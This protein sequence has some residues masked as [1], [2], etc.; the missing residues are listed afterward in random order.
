MLSVLTATLVLVQTDWK[1]YDLEGIKLSLPTTPKRVYPEGAPASVRNWHAT[2]GRNGVGVSIQPSDPNKSPDVN[3]AS[4]LGGFMSAYRGRLTAQSDTVLN[5]WPG[6]DATLNFPGLGELRYVSYWTEKGLVTVTAGGP[7]QDSVAFGKRVVES[8]SLGSTFSKGPQKTAGPTWKRTVL[9]PSTVSIEFP[10]EP[11]SRGA[12]ESKDDGFRPHVWSATYGNREY[13]VVLV[14]GP[15]QKDDEAARWKS[16]QTI[17]TG[18]LTGRRAKYLSRKPS[19]LLGEKS[20]KIEGESSDGATAILA[21][22]TVKGKETFV[23]VASVPKVLRDSAEVTRFF[24][25]LKP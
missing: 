3:L 6:I 18:T 17:N 15:E 16:I 22:T 5:G 25:S 11:I 24:S 12:R 1:T 21:E 8:L 4:S 2:E 23:L 13:F 7:E 20:E 9:A 10:K 19:T 14:T